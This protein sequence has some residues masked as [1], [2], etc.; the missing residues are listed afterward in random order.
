MTWSAT[1]ARLT[2]GT[3]P[4][5]GNSVTIDGVTNYGI[6]RSP[7]EAVLDGV[8]VVSDFM[9][10]LPFAIWEDIEEGTSVRVDG[11]S[12]AARESSRPGV[13]R[14]TVWVPLELS[15]RPVGTCLVTLSGDAITTLDGSFITTL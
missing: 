6:L 1:A 14:S 3:M 8:V 11:V 13:D 15:P 12:Y 7:E 9:L 2:A 10:E 4:A 5:L